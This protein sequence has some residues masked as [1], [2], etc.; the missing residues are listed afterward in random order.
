[1]CSEPGEALGVCDDRNEAPEHQLEQSFVKSRR[2][3][4]MRWLDQHVTAVTQRQDLPRSQT[5]DEPRR[6]M[7]IC[8][9]GQVEGETD[10]VHL[11]LKCGHG[12]ADAG[13]GV[14]IEARQDVRRASD[15]TDALRDERFGHGER[16]REIARTV[17]DAGQDMA[18]QVDH[19]ATQTQDDE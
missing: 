3:D 18:M 19:G 7:N 8:A 13:S 2:Q 1:M 9:R 6:D 10:P 14:V 16:R 5:G 17:V 15:H 12:G 11:R 4:V